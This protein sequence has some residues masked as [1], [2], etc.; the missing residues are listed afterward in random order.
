MK[1]NKQINNK[2]KKFRKINGGSINTKFV[3]ACRLGLVEDA[4]NELKTLKLIL[5]LK[6]M[7]V[8]QLFS[9]RVYGVT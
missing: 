8:I 7:K 2:S 3:N 9:M 4:M 1:S 5:I 6:I